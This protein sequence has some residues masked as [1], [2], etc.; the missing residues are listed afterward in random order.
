M[1][2][3]LQVNKVEKT[4]SNVQTHHILHKITGRISV[5]TFK[6][7]TIFCDWLSLPYWRFILC[8]T[9]KTMHHNST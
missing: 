6:T 3:K 9:T 1:L 5:C 8:C 7:Y 2:T 4:Y